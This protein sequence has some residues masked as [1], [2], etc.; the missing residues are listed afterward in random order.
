MH[1][2]GINGGLRLAKNFTSALKRSM[3]RREL[4]KGVELAFPIGL[5]EELG[6]Q[7]VAADGRESRAG[8]KRTMSG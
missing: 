1:V 6:E 8:R 3:R 5:G 7:S 4:I 2:H